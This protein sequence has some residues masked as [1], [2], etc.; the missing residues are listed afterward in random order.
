MD[1]PAALLSAYIVLILLRVCLICLVFVQEF[2]MIIL[3]ELRMFQLVLYHKN[4]SSLL[5]ICFN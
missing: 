1:T 2:E 3:Y 5:T 4:V